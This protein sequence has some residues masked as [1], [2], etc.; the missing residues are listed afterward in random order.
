MKLNTQRQKPGRRRRVSIPG[1][2]IALGASIAL[3]WIADGIWRGFLY[4]APEP[5][6]WLSIEGTFADQPTE[7]P[8]AVMLSAET[9]PTEAPAETT[10]SDPFAE[11]Q[12]AAFR[13]INVHVPSNCVMMTQES[14]ALRSGKLLRLDSEHSYSGYEGEFVDF[15]GSAGGYDVRFSELETLPCVVDAMDK[16]AAGY[17]A[18]TGQHDLLI[19]STTSACSA[20]GSIYPDELPDRAPGYAV[21]LAYLNEEGNIVPMYTRDIW[22]ENNAYRYGFVFSYTEAD[23]EATGFPDAPYHLR[24]VGKVHAGLMQE[25]GLTLAAYQE[26]LQKHSTDDPLLYESDDQTYSVYYVPKSLGKTDV[27]VPK[28]GNY[29]ISGDNDTGFVVVA[30]GKIQ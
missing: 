12:Q 21:D 3:I 7:V 28:N 22:L 18:A 25:L 4:E 8:D 16:L 14:S 26:E 17:L 23:E 29:E 1:G 5:E 19:Y 10:E 13:P 2:L 20:N 27:P 30:E 15:S 11:T 6:V 9:M 24:F